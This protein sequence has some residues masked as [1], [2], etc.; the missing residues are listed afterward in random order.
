MLIFSWSL[1]VPSWS[2]KRMFR[3]MNPPEKI[4]PEG[5]KEKKRDYCDMHTA[6]WKSVVE[7]KEN[8]CKQGGGWPQYLS[9]KY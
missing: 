9:L 4:F 1:F 3:E 7:G 5:E 6:N 2:N 8:A